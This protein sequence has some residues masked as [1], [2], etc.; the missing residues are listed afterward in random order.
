MGMF[1]GFFVVCFLLALILVG[2]MG[3]FAHFGNKRD[4]K[5]ID[6]F[7]RKNRINIADSSRFWDGH[8]IIYDNSNRMFWIYKPSSE[9]YASIP[10]ESLLGCELRID[11]NTEYRASVSS[12]AGRAVI[13]GVLFGGLGAIIGGVTGKK[14]STTLVHKATLTIYYDF[15]KGFTEI[16][17]FSDVRGSRM[18]SNDF[19]GKYN[20]AMSWCKFIER[21]T[22]N[23]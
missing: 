1:I 6:S 14:N 2:I 21:F 5:R 11:N 15:S 13:G 12:A 7:I 18:D 10:T 3:I 20:V 19:R 4:S 16:E 17:I 22:E 8:Y 9:Y 23:R